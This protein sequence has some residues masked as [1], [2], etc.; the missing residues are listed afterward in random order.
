[1]NHKGQQIQGIH[2]LGGCARHAKQKISSKPEKHKVGKLRFKIQI[3]NKT[4]ALGY[5]IL[6]ISKLY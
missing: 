5:K 2:V 4:I 1:M 3:A 6:T